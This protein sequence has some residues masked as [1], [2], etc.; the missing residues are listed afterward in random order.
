MVT[1]PSAK[2][3]LKGGTT[4]KRGYNKTDAANTWLYDADYS[5]YTTT[6]VNNQPVVTVTPQGGALF[7]DKDATV[8][9][10]GLVSIEGNK[11]KK[12]TGTVI[13]N[14]YL[15]TFDKSLTISGPLDVDTKIGVTSPVRNTADSYEGNTLSPVAEA[16]L[17]DAD[18]PEYAADTTAKAWRHDNFLD[19][20]NWFF[21]NG[22]HTTYYD[23]LGYE[24][25]GNE[26]RSLY[27]GWTWANVV[28][29]APSEFD[30]SNIDS[31]EDLAWLISLNTGMNGATATN[32]SG[33]DLL[34]KTDL[35]MK[36][37]VWVPIGDDSHNGFEHK[38]FA[39]HFDGQGHLIKNLNIDY[40]GRGDTRYEHQDYGLFGHVNGSVERTFVVSGKVSPKISVDFGS[41]DVFNVGGLVGRLEGSNAFVANSEAAL[42]IYYPSNADE[43]ITAGGLVANLLSGEVRS[44][45]AMPRISTT[46]VSAGSV[47]GL[48]GSAKA[49]KITNSFVN[50]TFTITGSP[51]AG[52][53]LGTNAGA[54]MSNCYVNW[55]GDPSETTFKG[56]VN[57]STAGSITN[58][59]YRSQDG[60]ESGDANGKA[61]SAPYSSDKYGYMYSDNFVV[62]DK[63]LFERLN[64]NAYKLNRAVTPA[65]SD[66][67]YAHWARPALSEING[68]LP[69]L[70]LGEFDAVN[71]YQGG[72]RSV[73]T[74]A[75]TTALQYGGPV[76]D[77]ST[78]EL[79]GAIGRME[80]G[81]AL[82]VY[83]D[84]T[85][86]PTETPEPKTKISIQEDVSIMNPGSLG[87]YDSNYV[88]ITFDNSCGEATATPSMNGVL[89]PEMLKLPRD[90][91]MFST[92]L[93]DAPLGFNY[94]IGNTNT[95][96]TGYPGTSGN[97][98][99][100]NPW[101]NEGNEFSWLNNGGEGDVRYWMYGWENSQ[102]QNDP[103]KILGADWKDGYFPSQT[104]EFG[105]G[106]ISGVGADEYPSEGHKRYP[107]GMDFYT[108]NEPEH[109]WIN[110]K[111]NGPNHWHSEP[112]HNHL[113]YL[114]AKVQSGQTAF[115]VNQNEDNLILGRG[116]MASIATGTFMQS[117]GTLNNVNTSIMLTNNGWR[118]EGWN[119]VGNPYH[120]YL[121]F[122]LVARDNADI[123]STK[124]DDND[125]SRPFYVVYD[126]DKYLNGNASTAYRY[127]VPTCSSGG[128]YA[129]QY[130]HPHQGFYVR[131]NE[132]VNSDGAPLNFTQGMLATRQT[133]ITENEESHFRA[134]RPA[135]PL[136]N[137]YLSSDKG[138]A[139]VTV[140]EFE[141]PEWG[142]ARKVKELRVG[143]GLFY[144]HHDGTYYAAL[145]A[146]EGVDRV[147]LWFEAKDDD[148]FTMKWNKANA[149][150]HSMYLID[151]IAGVQYDMLRNDTYSF[152]G[153]RDDYPSR[154]LIVF[155]LTGV[156]EFE[157]DDDHPFAFFNGSEWVVTGDG[158]LQFIDMLGQVLAQKHISGQ[159]RI[160]LPKVADGPYLFRLTNSK[161][162]KIQKVIVTK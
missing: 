134:S 25:A 57:T 132:T 147:P 145:F 4:L 7:V 26:Y 125:V 80:E 124:K 90:W 66:S 126:A 131:A 84:I 9:V 100:H 38:S 41:T 139:D 6:Q 70:L 81:D 69:V 19:D 47:G 102:S 50:G 128:D 158:D 112:P 24:S 17:V 52:G 136:V 79:D 144:A 138:S 137:L 113:E 153:H 68:D 115:T 27:F 14:V 8:N 59:Y 93:K 37:Y 55:D 13:S 152:E 10:E 154:F 104:T 35:D 96:E 114:P 150:F 15:P 42:S 56:V 156:E 89:D 43:R 36:Q 121:N 88:G 46:S 135:Y 53:L 98:Y 148:I 77:G 108:W 71:A 120:G 29:E 161:E 127:Y 1:E 30:V 129:D 106:L 44:S 107:Y 162:T 23:N 65:V 159:T 62:E 5:C 49:G 97:E 32:F 92:P 21:G 86:T 142:G 83:G 34:Q 39:G 155:D 11:Q 2:L 28:R 101:L 67:L 94:N 73:S 74:Y 85:T 22:G 63:P 45:M 76:R 78:N 111:R 157:E 75:G 119:L 133:L 117:H 149:D 123:L 110:F 146:K 109:H 141:R 61:F 48:V 105:A 51:K 33:Q 160:F 151:N 99:Y 91:H 130:I 20:Q 122:D 54:T 12:G 140:I 95:N 116:Y 64:L 143:D 58:C 118:L 18:H 103:T 60:I 40:I 87:S 82:F 72:F 16:I 31:K 3:T